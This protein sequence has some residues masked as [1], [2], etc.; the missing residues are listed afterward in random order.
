[1]DDT[2][3]RMTRASLH[4][5]AELLIAGPQYRIFETIRL[6]AAL[7]GFGGVR[8]AVSAVGTELVGPGGRVPL[9]GTYG[10]IASALDLVPGPP[11]GVYADGSGAR[12]TDEVRVD[13]DAASLIGDWFGVGDAAL[14][15]LAPDTTPVLWPEHFDLSATVDDVNYGVSPGDGQHPGPYA[16]VGPWTARTGAF[17]NASFGA[18]RP[19][20][21]VATV[22]SLLSFFEEGRRNAAAG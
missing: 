9:E 1:M 14:R 19:R 20:E 18:L 6:R 2:T 21:E 7:G 8:L 5:V 17:W 16:Y 15:R 22:A 12:L 13:R 11:E 10:A 4:G 3:Y